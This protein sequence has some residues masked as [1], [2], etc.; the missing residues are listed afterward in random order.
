MGSDLSKEELQRNPPQV[1]T[2]R[3]YYFQVQSSFDSIGFL[4]P[5]L[6]HAKVL[7]RKTGEGKYSNLKWDD[8][9]PM[10]L[11]IEMTSFFV[12]FFELENIEI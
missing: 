5:F 4:I 2:R 11:V 10:D 8:P 12:D 3:Q 7:L 6:L 9:L 1:V